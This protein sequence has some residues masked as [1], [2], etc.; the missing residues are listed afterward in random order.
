VNSGNYIE[1]LLFKLAYSFLSLLPFGV[2][3]RVCIISARIA[4]AIGMR[5]KIVGINLRTALGENLSEK[6]I[7]SMVKRCYEELGCAIAEIIKS[8]FIV[9]NSDSQSIHGLEIL[10]REFHS[11]KG[12]MVLTAH[13]GNFLG[14]GY[15]L[16]DMGVHLNVVGK[17]IHNPLLN[18]EFNKIREKYGNRLIQISG[19]RNDPS[20]GY[21]I[22]KT[23]KKGEIVVIL[24]DQDAGPDGYFG[25]FF[26]IP[27]SIPSGP[28]RFAYRTGS[29]VTTGFAGRNDRKL[30]MEIQD[31]ID[32]S[33]AGSEEEAERI[34]LDE[35][36]KRLEEKVRKSPELYFWF[37]KKWKSTPKI[38]RRYSS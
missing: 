9:R 4:C 22:F 21:R 7:E 18:M 28:A 11:G 34:I 33:Q 31:P 29:T 1:Y 14:C 10:Q 5:K 25:T 38:S 19:A 2:L 32:C 26:G 27:S 15:I 35:Y 37:H 17:P 3:R 20:G 6:E 12:V 16:G 23:L 24:N 8:D 13:M 30:V 36:S